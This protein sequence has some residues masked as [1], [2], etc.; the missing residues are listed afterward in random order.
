MSETPAKHAKIISEISTAVQSTPRTTAPF[1]DINSRE[2]S[3][4]LLL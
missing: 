2:H 1:T 4:V 3:S